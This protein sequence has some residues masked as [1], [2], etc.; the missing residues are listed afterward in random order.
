MKQYV[1]VYVQHTYM[2]VYTYTHVY[3]MYTQYIW[4]CTCTYTFN[5]YITYVIHKYIYTHYISITMWLFCKFNRDINKNV[6]GI[7]SWYTFSSNFVHKCLIRFENGCD[8]V[9]HYKEDIKIY[10]TFYLSVNSALKL[11]ERNI[12]G[13][14]LLE[15]VWF[16]CISVL[17]N[18]IYTTDYVMEACKIILKIYA[19]NLK[20]KITPSHW[21]LLHLT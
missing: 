11:D 19:H 2:C 3:I 18:F 7:K 10:K 17:S 13:I 15:Y 16:R 21:H 5:M 6:S 12:L 14:F 9:S 1:C 4:V 20:N 8:F